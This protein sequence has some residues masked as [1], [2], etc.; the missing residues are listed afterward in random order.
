MAPTAQAELAFDGEETGNGA[1][2]GKPVASSEGKS[3]AVG[4][5]ETDPPSG[6]QTD[7]GPAVAENEEAVPGSEAAET[8]Q[9]KA[10]PE[11]GWTNI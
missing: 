11:P 8:A 6:P 5:K 2:D 7:A 4:P 3:D 1:G 10:R 9:S